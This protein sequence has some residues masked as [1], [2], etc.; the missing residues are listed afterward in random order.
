MDRSPN[1]TKTPSFDWEALVPLL[2]HPVKV[3][4]IEVMEWTDLPLSATD[5]DRILDGK[6]GVSLISYHL[7]KLAELEI[8]KAVRKD[9]VRG[10]VQTFYELVGSSSS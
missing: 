8:I 10:A 3:E 4:I 7:R 1:F 5:L 9:T 6:I 2:I